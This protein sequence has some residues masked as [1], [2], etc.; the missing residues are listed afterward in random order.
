M[1]F[2][3]FGSPEEGP[4]KTGNTAEPTIIR[5]LMSDRVRHG[6]SAAG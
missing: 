3:G 1:N 2:V 4:M 6:G 5:D